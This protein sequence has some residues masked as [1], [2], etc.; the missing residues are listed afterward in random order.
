MRLLIAL[1]LAVGAVAQVPMSQPF[2][3]PLQPRLSWLGNRNAIPGYGLV[4]AWD[5]T[6]DNL[7]KWS[8]SFCDAA[9]VSSSATCTANTHTSPVG[10][11]TAD[12]ITSTGANGYIRQASP[13]AVGQDYTFSVWLR[14]LTGETLNLQ[15]TVVRADFGASIKT[16]VAITTEWQRLAYTFTL[17]AGYEGGSVMIGGGSTFST[18]LSLAA[19][20]AQLTEGSTPKPYVRTTDGQSVPNFAPGQTAALQRGS[21]A[22]ADTNDPT[23]SQQ[24]MVFDGVDDFLANIPA[25][26][27]AWTVICVSPTEVNAVDSAGGGYVNGVAN[28]AAAECDPGTSGAYTG[29]L[30]KYLMYNRV[31]SPVD[32]ANAYRYWRTLFGPVKGLTL[33]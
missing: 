33:P 11:Q 18:G 30:S 4:G 26:A 31:L 23:L 21:T 16:N 25:K 7:L 5:L 8:E 24:G 20:G 17:P 14:S 13:V 9:W 10:D 2:G 27:A 6:S 28:P 15:L 32:H 1:L 29:T 22:G 3:L 12:T 19:W